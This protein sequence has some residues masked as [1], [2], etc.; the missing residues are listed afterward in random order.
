MGYCIKYI[1]SIVPFLL[2]QPND[3]NPDLLHFHDWL[4]NQPCTRITKFVIP[5]SLTIHSQSV[6]FTH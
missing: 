2:L 5:I 6:K 1:T 3:F 4:Q